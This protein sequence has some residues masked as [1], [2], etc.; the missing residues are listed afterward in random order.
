MID[1]LLSHLRG[2]QYICLS[3]NSLR[4]SCTYEMQPH[5]C[6]DNQQGLSEKK[7]TKHETMKFS[8]LLFSPEAIEIFWVLL[9]VFLLV[10][11]QWRS[12]TLQVW[13]KLRWTE[14]E[15]YPNP[16][17]AVILLPLSMTSSS[18]YVP[19]SCVWRPHWTL[20]LT[21]YIHTWPYQRQSIWPPR[22]SS[23]T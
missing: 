10:S 4:L 22:P 12:T 6:M 18:V 2:V 19:H 3:Q 9:F 7:F 13:R 8:K 16:S 21:S 5:M 14:G 17:C 1:R 20:A 23:A 15:C 11:E